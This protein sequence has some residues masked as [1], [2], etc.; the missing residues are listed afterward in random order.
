MSNV[1]FLWEPP[2]AL[3]GLVSMLLMHVLLIRATCWTRLKKGC[4]GFATMTI[5]E[6][7]KKYPYCFVKEICG[8]SLLKSIFLLGMTEDTERSIIKGHVHLPTRSPHTDLGLEAN[9]WISLLLFSFLRPCSPFVLDLLSA[10]TIT[11]ITPS[12]FLLGTVQRLRC[13]LLFKH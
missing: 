9:A 5:K 13:L 3:D 7:K 11:T 6:R 8:I 1:I 4:Y 12:L 2:C 10:N